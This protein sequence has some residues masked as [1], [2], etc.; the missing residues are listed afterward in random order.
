MGFR[1]TLHFRNFKVVLNPMYRFLQYLLARHIRF[2]EFSVFKTRH[3]MPGLS[4]ILSLTSF[5]VIFRLM[6][7]PFLIKQLEGVME[8]GS[9]VSS[10]LRPS[11]NLL[12]ISHFGSFV[13]RTPVQKNK[14]RRRTT[15]IALDC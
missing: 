1:A 8:S 7:P 12:L 9:T 5:Q 4:A 10:S 13:D 6:F 11:P 14:R 15:F 2:S 3:C